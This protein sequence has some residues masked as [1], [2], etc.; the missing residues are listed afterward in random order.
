MRTLAVA[1]EATLFIADIVLLL[2]PPM[3]E[4]SSRLALPWRKADSELDALRRE[5]FLR[6]R[7][8]RQDVKG[9]G[10]TIHASGRLIPSPLFAMEAQADSELDALRRESFLRIRCRRQDVKGFR[11]VKMGAVI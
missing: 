8:R 3:I 4:F 6:I 2:T 9:C 7:C 1:G 11:I 10:E 5:S